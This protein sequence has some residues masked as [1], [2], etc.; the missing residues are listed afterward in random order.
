MFP[1]Q[2]PEKFIRQH[3]AGGIGDPKV[4]LPDIL[5][6]IDDIDRAA[7]AGP[8]YQSSALLEY[9]DDYVLWVSGS[10]HGA[11]LWIPG[12]CWG[13]DY[14]TTENLALW[15]YSGIFEV[16]KQVGGAGGAAVTW[17]QLVL[18][19]SGTWRQNRG[20]RC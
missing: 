8:G 5:D 16:P 15:A 6:V 12:Y 19:H 20:H 9:E 18:T 17:G 11:L 10:G 1:E 14:G 3:W 4:D 7:S 13:F 2:H